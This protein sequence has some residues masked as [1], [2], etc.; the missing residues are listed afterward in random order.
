MGSYGEG[1]Q[2]P[3]WVVAQVLGEGHCLCF[4]DGGPAG[5]TALQPS[6]PSPIFGA[7]G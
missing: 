7:R 2:P 6:P 1:G 5:V 4:A 3:V